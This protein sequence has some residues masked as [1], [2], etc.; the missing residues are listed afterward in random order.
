MRS[1]SAL[2]SGGARLLILAM[3]SMVLV[4]LGCTGAQAAAETSLPSMSSPAQLGP[5]SEHV[6][7]DAVSF[8]APAPNQTACS[9]GRDTVQL[10]HNALVPTN[11]LLQHSP[12]SSRAALPHLHPDLAAERQSGRIPAALTHLD[13]GIVRT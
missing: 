3:T 7:L 13:L 6:V 9:P 11:A 10:E 1:T 5:V 4:V 2:L 12:S 8:D